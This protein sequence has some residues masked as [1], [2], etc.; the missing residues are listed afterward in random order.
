MAKQRYPE[1]TVRALVFNPERKLLLVQSHKWRNKY[2]IPGGHIELGE[3]LLAA[4]S[5]EVKEETGLDV[6]DAEFIGFQ[7]FIFDDAFWKKRHFL[8]FDY[9]CK[10]DSTDV[11]LNSESEEYLW[12]SLEDAAHLPVDP[13]TQRTI[14]EYVKKHSE[15]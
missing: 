2:T 10:T 6:Y 9:A 7:E 12:I 14:Q 1:P 4:L 13:Y 15:R 11:K 3:T 5:R 8:F